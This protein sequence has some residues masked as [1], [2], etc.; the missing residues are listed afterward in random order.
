MLDVTIIMPFL[1]EGREPLNTIDSILDSTERVNYEF[2]LV[3]DS[4]NDPEFIDELDSYKDKVN[5]TLLKN[6]KRFGCHYSRGVGIKHA[7]TPYIITMDA[8]MRFIRN[9]WLD[10]LLEN[11]K[12][13][14]CTI[15]SSV[16]TNV[17]EDETFGNSMGYGCDILFKNDND[18][19]KIDD[20]ILSP[21]WRYKSQLL[22][23][24]EIPCLMG[25]CYIMS[26]EWINHIGRQD[27][28]IYWG[29]TEACMSLKTWLMGGQCKILPEVIVG[30]IYRKS[31]VPYEL[32]NWYKFYNKMYLIYTLFPE[33]EIQKA[34]DELGKN[35]QQF[36][37]QALE[38]F[39]SKKGE[40][41]SERVKYQKLLVHDIH[42]FIDKFKQKSIF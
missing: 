8:H 17:K 24:N 10:S 26:R 42:W 14:P 12:K 36:Y 16:T 40:I 38:H 15:F 39:E 35:H 28:L 23:S 34:F 33:N 20:S 1:N 4:P 18:Y 2:I 9:G 7:T 6:P 13:E 11:I 37:N 27:G 19:E 22:D 41:D 30:H 32:K 29:S 5:I 31:V 25:A 3:H 21:K